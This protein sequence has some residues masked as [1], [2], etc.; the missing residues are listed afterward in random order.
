MINLFFKIDRDP[1]TV[2]NIT[3]LDDVTSSG[4]LA[5]SFKSNDEG[6]G[7]RMTNIYSDDGKYNNSSGRVSLAHRN[8]SR[9]VTSSSGIF[10]TGG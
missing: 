6:A 10:S 7:V 2:E 8:R 4:I 5:V 9:I 1:A 3:V